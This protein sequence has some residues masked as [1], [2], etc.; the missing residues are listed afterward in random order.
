MTPTRG[1]GQELFEILRAGLGRVGSGQEVLSYHGSGPVT[2]TRDPNRPTAA[3]KIF[4][5]EKTLCSLF[6]GRGRQEHTYM[7]AAHIYTNLR[8]EIEET[9]RKKKDIIVTLVGEIYHLHIYHLPINHLQ[10]D[11]L[12]YIDKSSSD[13]LQ[14][15]IY[16]G[17]IYS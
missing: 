15:I 5:R 1:S 17:F 7:Y 6:F 4:F 2:V 14:K 3:L 9:R 8:Q 13:Q 12:R 11:H 16:R 10:I